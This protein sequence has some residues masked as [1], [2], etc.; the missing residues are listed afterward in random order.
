MYG[1]RQENGVYVAE[2]W[3]NELIFSKP[4]KEVKSTLRKLFLG[5]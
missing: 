5:Y 4:E 1:A 3:V 2:R